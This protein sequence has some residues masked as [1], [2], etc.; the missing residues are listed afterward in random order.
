M[1]HRRRLT[2]LRIVAA[3]LLSGAPADAQQAT[4]RAAAAE[5]LFQEGKALMAARN[6]SAACPKLAESQRLDPGSG[7]LTALALCHEGE[8]KTASAWAEFME[9]VGTARKDGRIDREKFA[10]SHA[11]ALEGALSRLTIDVPPSVSAVGGLGVR[12]DGEE[13]GQAA[14][15]T[16][17]AVDPGDHVIEASAPG[18]LAWKTTVRVGPQG[19]KQTVSV[20]ALA[21]EPPR[22]AAAPVAPPAPVPA[23]GPKVPGLIL[24][25]AGLVVLGVGSAFGV[26]AILKS[27]DVKSAC[28]TATGCSATVVSENNTAKSFAL[29]SDI[30][31][32][33]GAAAVVA[34]VVLVL[35][36]RGGGASPARGTRLL[37]A[38]ARDGAGVVW[39]ADF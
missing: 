10:R 27:H 32:G 13:V 36:S 20:P 38:V 18:K 7:T 34:G 17:L 29:V 22:S 23:W 19:D 2:A 21:D 39:A 37:P 35:T 15:G 31:M 14:W 24:G 16:P 1:P 5:S 8:G 33:A 11:A 3:V 28:P 25:G 12:R 6:F 26:E 4:D 30:T 9:V